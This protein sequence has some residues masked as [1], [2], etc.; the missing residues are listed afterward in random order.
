ML[1]VYKHV[2]QMATCPLNRL[3]AQIISDQIYFLRYIL[4]NVE[5]IKSYISK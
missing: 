3:L 1:H 4:I 2:L 5:V